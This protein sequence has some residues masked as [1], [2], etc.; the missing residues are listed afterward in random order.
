VIAEA[1]IGSLERS[2][3]ASVAPDR[4]VEIGAWLVPLNDGAIGRAKSA[5]P[6]R[7]DADPAAIAD[8]EAVY[9][10]AGLPPAFRIAE[11]AA[12]AEVRDA[13]AR[14]GY[15]PHTPTIMKIGTAAG[16]AALGGEP[17]ELFA[18]PDAAWIAAFTGDG[19]D[20]QE[21]ASRVR[22]LARSPD[23]LFAAVRE[24]DRTL[25][26]GLGSFGGV[27]VGVHG[28]RTAPEG[29][30]RGFASRI[31]CAIGREAQRRGL[32]RAV[33]EVVEDNPARSLYRAA[34]FEYA[35]RYQY[36]AKT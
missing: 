2:I 20:P 9:A 16:L 22:N 10:A 5:V 23:A 24:G 7:H 11:T 27:W 26:V 28:M 31:L 34:G 15:A 29:R 4:T 18:K 6:L 32:D 12:L 3:V 35:W 19:F 8:I 14:R 36:W 30:R 17:A 21:G 25:A 13:L 1:D 33:L